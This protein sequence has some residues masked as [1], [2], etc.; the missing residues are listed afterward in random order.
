MT[1]GKLK[2]CNLEYLFD[3]AKGDD[4][5]VK[6]MLEVFLTENPEE[7]EHLSRAI[8]SRNYSDI[9]QIAHKLRSSIPY[10]G[11]DSI[12]GEDVSQMEDLGGEGR[13]IEKIEAHFARVKEICTRACHELKQ[14]KL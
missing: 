6:E 2:I 13:D 9:K 1:G 14:L 11:L 12:I 4:E 10:V 7:L 8:K 3:L 5:F